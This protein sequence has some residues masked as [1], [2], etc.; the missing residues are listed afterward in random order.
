MKPVGS[1]SG[2]LACGVAAG[3]LLVVTAAEAAVGNVVISDVK[4]TAQYSEAGGE[5]QTLTTRKTLG[6]G[7]TL[8]TGVSSQIELF[9]K[10]N[11]P[12][13]L[14]AD[15]TLSLDKLNID[16]S[17][18]EVVVE[19]QLNLTKGTIQGHVDK[20]ATASKYEVKTPHDVIGVRATAGPV[21]FQISADDRVHVREGSLIVVYTAPG[22][23]PIQNTVNAG[24]T[25]NPP[26]TAGALPTIVPITI[27]PIPPFVPTPPPPPT[28]IVVVPEPV[29]FVSPGTG[30]R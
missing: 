14:L 18:V 22:Q 16:R 3:A 7:T 17:G 8:K 15:T 6:P 21:D 25:F 30:T 23:A 9:I 2:W 13:R 12:L 1:F 28:P 26:T 24:Q 20:L 29:V 10:N 19:T 5:W 4:G 11:G 27:G